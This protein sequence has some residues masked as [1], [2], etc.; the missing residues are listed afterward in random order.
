MAEMVW[1]VRDL[2]RMRKREVWRKGEREWLIL[3]WA[4]E[5]KE[6]GGGGKGEKLGESKILSRENG[7]N[8]IQRCIAHDGRSS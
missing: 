3:G 1:K 6:R 8:G 5:G 2:E 4:R 7:M